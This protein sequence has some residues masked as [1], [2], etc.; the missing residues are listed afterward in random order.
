MAAIQPN[1]KCT[2]KN[3][4]FVSHSLSVSTKY[5][6]TP[7]ECL[8]YLYLSYNTKCCS[9][10]AAILYQRL[11]QLLWLTPTL[12]T[13]SVHISVPTDIKTCM[14]LCTDV[15]FSTLQQHAGIFKLTSCF[16]ISLTW[17]KTKWIWNLSI[18]LDTCMY[19][20][21]YLLYIIVCHTVL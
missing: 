16:H 13:I 5:M 10:P 1:V 7:S 9:Q 17:L 15:T 12:V 19:L 3:K 8:L 18:C 11:L 14:L 6:L 2:C 4:Q 20:C 21:M